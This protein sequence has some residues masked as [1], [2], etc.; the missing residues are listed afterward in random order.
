[1]FEIINVQM[2]TFV[3]QMNECA[4]ISSFV[5]HKLP[6]ISLSVFPTQAAYVWRSWR[7]RAARLYQKNADSYVVLLECDIVQ[8]HAWHY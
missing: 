1:M 8:E 6:R 5:L 4:L 3:K 7:T 2:F